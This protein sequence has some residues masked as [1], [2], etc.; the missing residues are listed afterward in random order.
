[1]KE[2]G[3]SR[4]KVLRDEISPRRAILG[5]KGR[6]ERMFSESKDGSSKKAESERGNNIFEVRRQQDLR[7]LSLHLHSRGTT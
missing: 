3:V 7:M 2:T 4:T 5:I 1:M 6:H